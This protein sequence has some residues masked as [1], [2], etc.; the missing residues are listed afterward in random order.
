MKLKLTHLSDQDVQIAVIDSGIDPTHPGVGHVPE[1]ARISIEANGQIESAIDSPPCSGHGTACAGIIRQKAPVIALYSIRI[2]DESL[3]ADGH[4]LIT[5]IRWTIEHQMDVVNLSL[6]TTDITFRDELADVCRQAREAGI[7]LVAAEHNEGRESYPAVF[8]DVI[9]VTGG[10]VQGRFGYYYRPGEKIECVARG[11]MQR[12]CWTHPRYIMVSGTSFAAPHITGIVALIRQAYPGASLE[13]VREILQANTLEGNPELSQNTDQPHVPVSS[14]APAAVTHSD[15]FNPHKV[16]LYPFNKEMHALVRS[17]DLLNFR[18]IGIADPP[19]KRL[20]GKDAGEA[21]G[22]QPIGVCIQPR[23]HAALDGADTLI[24]GYVD[25]LSRIGKKD[26]LR[27]SI[28]TALDHNCHIFSF[29]TVQRD[30]YG[31]LYEQAEKKGLHITFPSISLKEA[32]YSIQ[33]GSPHGP[34]DVPVLGIFGT[35]A[36]QGKFT[37][38]LALRR[39]LLQKGYKIGQI[40][41]EHHS[42]LFGMDFSFPIGYATPLSLPVQWYVPYLDFKMREI[43]HQTHPDIILVGAQSGTI[44][45]DVHEHST[46]SLSSIA[47]LLGTKPDACI[48]V[49]NSIDADAYIQDTIDGIRTLTKAPTILLAMSDKEKHIRAA[50]GRTFIKPRLMTPEEIDGKL[51]HLEDRFGLPAVGIL[52]AEGQQQVVE[53]VINHFATDDEETLCQMKR[54]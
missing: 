43:C 30:T 50:Y 53:T 20:A 42:A 29:L 12:V 16:A 25:Q 46:H 33:A 23:L 1:K 7:I 27:Q 40:G 39:Q 14:P 3:I 48:L 51:R 22:I 35:S 6:G 10:K 31:D 24:L 4:A 49:V 19:G 17:T 45:Y 37:L 52:S 47:F 13:Q 32:Q 9:G 2:F 44:P 36:Q 8:S 54:A 38:Q 15:P 28:Q 11:D 5:A 18:I 34:V 21:L 26:L 41:T